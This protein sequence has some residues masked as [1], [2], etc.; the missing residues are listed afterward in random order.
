MTYT[1]CRGAIVPLEPQVPRCEAFRHYCSQ[2]SPRR[3]LAAK[4]PAA[5]GTPR[6]ILATSEKTMLVQAEVASPARLRTVPSC[7]G[8]WTPVPTEVV[9]PARL[10]AL[11]SSR[12]EAAAL[13]DEL[14]ERLTAEPR[15][16]YADQMRLID[17]GMAEAARQARS[18]CAERGAA[19]ELLR[20][21]YARLMAV[22]Q[23]PARREGLADSLRRELRREQARATE[24]AQQ[25]EKVRVHEQ[26]LEVQRN[27]G[28]AASQLVSAGGRLST[29]ASAS[30][31]DPT[32]LA[33][34]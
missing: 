4:D 9:S 17:F 24:L 30:A 18:H 7:H 6:S 5:A 23:G 19:L 10:R 2:P 34:G 22:L 32:G 15:L 12:T 25:L 27:K 28:L 3:T 31:S 20:A 33:E 1:V 26:A 13:Y 21:E 29:S 16:S 14:L 8:A 11:P